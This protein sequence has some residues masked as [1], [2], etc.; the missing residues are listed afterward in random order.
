VTRFPSLAAALGIPAGGGGAL[1]AFVGAGGKTSLMA[2][3]ERELSATGARVALATTTKVGGWQVQGAWEPVALSARD[4]GGDGPAAARARAAGKVPFFFSE[5][6][7]DGKLAGIPAEAA[8]ALAGGSDALLVEA[9][10]ARGCSFKV[11]RPHEPVVP[12]GTTHLCVVAGADIAR[13][14]VGPRLFFDLEKIAPEGGLVEGEPCPPGAVRRL[15][16]AQGGYLRF[17]GGRRR[18]FVLLNKVDSDADAAGAR[19][20]ADEL[21]SPRVE[22]ALLL[23]SRIGT[24][25]LRVDNAGCRIAGVVL[26]AG[27]SR[28]FG[29]GRQKVL[30]CARGTSLLERVAGAAC[31]SRLDEVVVVAGHR[32]DEVREALRRRRWARPLRVVENRRWQEGMA[33]SI[34]AGVADAAAGGAG[35]VMLLLGDMP[36][37]RPAL[38]DGVIGAFAGSNAR[39][40]YPARGEGHGHPVVFRKELFGELLALGGDA[41]ARAVVEANDAWAARFEGGD[42]W[43]Q[44]DIDTPAD[45]N[46]FLI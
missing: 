18:V 19:R 20:L 27:G 35:A 1:V 17:A 12:A 46:E 45:L 9:D 43:A 5:A 13:E 2:R 7:P 40:A 44:V 25:V 4:A 14:P 23:S 26:A 16:F 29:G 21:Y 3:L 10:G 42:E 31:A 33:S 32:G 34:A 36:R 22:P 8:G 28:R 38:V 6:L 37:V 24:G 15:L 11:P 30:A 39:L 41:G